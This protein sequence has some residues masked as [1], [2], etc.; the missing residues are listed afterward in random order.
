MP[1]RRHRRNASSSPSASETPHDRRH[2]CGDLPAQSQAAPVLIDDLY[3]DGKIALS[4]TPEPAERAPRPDGAR[5]ADGRQIA[6]GAPE[7]RLPPQPEIVVVKALRDDS[8]GRITKQ[9][10]IACRGR[11]SVFVARGCRLHAEQRRERPVQVETRP[12]AP[13]L[14]SARWRLSK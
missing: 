7:G 14:I 13:L 8:L 10:G 2:R 12:G 6:A 11:G 5:Y 3:E 4:A 9:A 1:R